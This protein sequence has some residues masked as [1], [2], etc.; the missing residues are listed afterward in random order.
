L[1]ARVA[2]V[3]KL[4]KN[5]KDNNIVHVDVITAHEPKDITAETIKEYVDVTKVADMPEQYA[6]SLKPLHV[7]QLSNSLKHLAALRHIIVTNDESRAYVVLEDDVLYNDD[8]A[9]VLK[10]TIA[11]RPEPCDLLFMGLPSTKTGTPE[12]IAYESGTNIFKS[13]PSCESYAMTLKGANLL[14]AKFLPIRFP[15]HIQLTY[16][17][18]VLNA[19]EMHVCSPNVFVDGSKIGVYMSSIEQNNFLMW[20][21]D[22]NKMNKM[23][24]QGSPIAEIMD[25]YNAAHFKEHP[26]FQYLAAQAYAKAGDHEKSNE[27]FDKAFNV[28]TSEKCVM[29]PDCMFMKDYVKIFRYKQK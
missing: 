18:K 2:N 20:N 17:I 3:N 29:S 22:Y 6:S 8:V 16:T 24:V 23:M 5:L 15:T 19:C 26:D 14:L 12:S 7:N 13:L 9:K 1:S 27:F 28:Y 25:V 11:N 10:T 4:I 21:S